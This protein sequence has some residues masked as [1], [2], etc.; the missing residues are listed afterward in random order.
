MN[1]KHT[2]SQIVTKLK[3]ADDLLGKSKSIS[4]V[5]KDLEISNRTYRRWRRKYRGMSPD[6]VEQIRVLQREHVRLISKIIGVC[7]VVSILVM[8]LWGLI[9]TYFF[10]RIFDVGFRECTPDAILPDLEKQYK[11]SFPPEIKDTK[12]ARTQGSWDSRSI[13]DFYIKFSA[14][15]NT[16]NTFLK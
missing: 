6:D 9:G 4:E 12:T 8:L 5:C 2:S 1:K 13:S 11:I 3:Q 7:L 10:V 16:V 15:P 14:D